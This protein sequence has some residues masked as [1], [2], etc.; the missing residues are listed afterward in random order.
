MFDPLHGIG[1]GRQ[2]VRHFCDEVNA[3][4][5]EVFDRYWVG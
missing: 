5:Q 1:I 4:L 3:C 2:A